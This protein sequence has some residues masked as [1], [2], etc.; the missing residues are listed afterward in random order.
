[1]HSATWLRGVRLRRWAKLSPS[2]ILNATLP[3]ALTAV[4]LASPSTG[5]VPAAA[6][7]TVLA[8]LIHPLPG[9]VR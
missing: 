1:V 6:P 9:P 8:P 2:A 5:A 4:M 3:A 7:V